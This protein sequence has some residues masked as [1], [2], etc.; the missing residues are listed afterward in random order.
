MT[1]QQAIAL[2]ALLTRYAGTENLRSV[3]VALRLAPSTLDAL[4]PGYIA[5]EI[6]TLTGE[7]RTV[8]QIRLAF[9]ISPEGDVS[10]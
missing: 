8:S 5:G 9:G 2:G 3:T 4:P 1:E 7:D 10:S 6:F